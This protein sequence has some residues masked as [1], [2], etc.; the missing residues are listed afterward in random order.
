[1]RELTEDE[2]HEKAEIIDTITAAIDAKNSG[3]DKQITPEMFEIYLEKSDGDPEM[4]EK[5]YYFHQNA[6]MTAEFAEEFPE[7]V[8]RALDMEKYEYEKVDCSI[9]VCF[10][11]KY[12]ITKDAYDDADNVFF[13]DFY[14][15]AA[16]YV[17]ASL[18]E[19]M[20]P[21]AVFEDS[22]GEIDLLA[23][24]YLEEFYVRSWN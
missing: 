19:V 23:I 14:S 10:I 8:E 21:D 7:I 13:S 15:D 3:G 11:Y 20:K 17:Y 24:P 6:E 9:G 5:G 16:D 2:K 22:F 18:L 1:M 4:Y 12:D